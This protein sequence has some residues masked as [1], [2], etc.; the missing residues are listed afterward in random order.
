MLTLHQPRR[1]L[2]SQPL[3]LILQQCVRKEVITIC[4]VDIVNFAQNAST[5]IPQ[6]KQH[7]LHVLLVTLPKG[8]GLHLLSS[9][10]VHI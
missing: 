7:V 1:S 10:E 9:V 5:R 3:D 6:A 4:L 8:L 2:L